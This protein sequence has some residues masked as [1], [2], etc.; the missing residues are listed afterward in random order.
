MV[1]VKPESSIFDLSL[2]TSDKNAD[3]LF[4]SFLLKIE[5]QDISPSTNFTIDDVVKLI[6][7]G[8][9]NVS[10][11]STYGF[12]ITSMFSNQ[13]GREYFIFEDYSMTKI[14]TDSCNNSNRDNYI[15]E[16]YFLEKKCRIN[17]KYII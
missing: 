2:L 15:W 6:P 12:S 5:E 16:K 4:K 13:K 10:N 8:T 7:R 14:F 3:K 9:A 17:P 1:M 11:Y